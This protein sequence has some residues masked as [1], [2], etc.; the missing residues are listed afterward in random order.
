LDPQVFALIFISFLYLL[1]IEMLLINMVWL[2]L[3]Y[4]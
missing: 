3:A 2:L 4:F 1:L